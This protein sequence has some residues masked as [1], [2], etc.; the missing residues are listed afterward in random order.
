MTLP[1]FQKHGYGRFLIEFS[2]LLS[3]REGRAGTPEKPLSDLG[4]ISYESFWKSKILFY[5]REHMHEKITVETISLATGFNVHDIGSTL[6]RLNLL[7]Y[8]KMADGTAL[9]KI[10]VRK[11]LLE[12][13]K[14]PKITVNEE[15]LRWIP[16]IFSSGAQLAIEGEDAAALSSIKSGP[17]T[18]SVQSPTKETVVNGEPSAI[19]GEVR[20]RKRRRK[21]N[22]TGYDTSSKIRKRKLQAAAAS[23]HVEEAESDVESSGEKNSDTSCP[24][25]TCIKPLFVETSTEEETDKE[26]EEEDEVLE[27]TIKNCSEIESMPSTLTNGDMNSLKTLSLEATD[28]GEKVKNGMH[29]SNGHKESPNNE[30]SGEED[31]KSKDVQIN[32]FSSLENSKHFE[33]LNVKFDQ[34]N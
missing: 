6:Q 23:K 2:Y 33:S 17:I 29:L 15:A 5:I 8:K 14:K 12:T 34:S 24:F 25:A 31:T 9:Y 22:K 10:F 3:K 7:R 26:E 11:E 32:E 16:L 28:I 30:Q 21:W 13:L 4:R 19:N 27:Q 18:E 1:V 20:K